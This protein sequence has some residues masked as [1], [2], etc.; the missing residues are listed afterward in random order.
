VPVPGLVLVALLLE[1]RLLAG[2]KVWLLEVA[3]RKELAWA[4]GT[5]GVNMD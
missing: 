5:G 2:V 3:R 4:V 1:M